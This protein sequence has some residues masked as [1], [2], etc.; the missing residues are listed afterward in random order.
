MSCDT[1]C[2]VLVQQV[3]G[4]TEDHVGGGVGVVVDRPDDGGDGGLVDVP[5]E[6]GGGEGASDGAVE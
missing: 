6:P 3:D 1:D 2:E 4:Q 5:L